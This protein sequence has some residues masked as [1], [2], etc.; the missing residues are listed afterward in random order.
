MMVSL[1]QLGDLTGVWKLIVAILSKPHRNRLA[2]LPARAPHDAPHRTRT[3][4]AAQEGAHR[5]VTHEVGSNRVLQSRPQAFC[6]LLLAEAQAR[7]PQEWGG[8]PVLARD[9]GHAA[10]DGDD[11]PR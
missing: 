3:E 10:P 11:V 6:R 4:P 9:I 1:V 5:N 2:P 7:L 8:T